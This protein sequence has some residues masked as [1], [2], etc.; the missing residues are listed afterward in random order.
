MNFQE[1]LAKLPLSPSE[2]II[3]MERSVNE[4]TIKINDIECLVVYAQGYQHVI[5]RPTEADGLISKE[6]WKDVLRDLRAMPW[7]SSRLHGWSHAGFLKGAT[8]LVDHGLQGFLRKDVKTF[9]WGHSLGG[10]LS[11]NC[12][13]LLCDMGFTIGGVITLGAPRTFTRG[14]AKRVKRLGYPIWEFSN[15]GDPIPDV[16]LRIWGYRHMNEIKTDRKRD[17]YSI[18]KNHS[19]T[20]YREAFGC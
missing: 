19:L 18:K 6:G 15:A 2:I 10:S 14:T 20:F 12:A 9:F 4:L 17:G 13:A 8:K 11:Q 1:E 7:Y 3:L 16:P 5:P